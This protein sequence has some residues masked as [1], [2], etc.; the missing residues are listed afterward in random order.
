MKLFASLLV[1][2]ALAIGAAAQTTTLPDNIYAG[3]IS[4]NSSASARFAGTGLYARKV[5]DGSGT[6]FFT[7]VDALPAT[8]SPFTVTTNF[9]AGVAQKL[10]FAL[11]KI[12]LYAPVGAGFSYNG[13][14]KGWEWNGG[15]LASVRLKGNWHL[16]P[17]ARFLKSSISNGSGY[18]PIVGV[19]IGWAQ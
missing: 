14:N 16:Y 1:V 12:P 9:G 6:Y 8:V 2:C 18:Q 5:N 10:P 19:M 4:F 3:G 11:G 15:I 17:N 7:A 13:T